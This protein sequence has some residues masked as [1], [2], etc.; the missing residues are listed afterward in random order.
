MRQVL[1]ILRN[2]PKNL[3]NPGEGSFGDDRHWFA[4][5]ASEAQELA[6]AGTFRAALHGKVVVLVGSLLSALLAHLER[7]SGL[8]L[9]DIPTKREH[10]L[11]LCTA[12][13]LSPLSSRLQ[14]EAPRNRMK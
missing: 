4:Q 12:S 5:I 10:W 8:E 1:H 7:N 6:L 14:N 2:T 3:K 13:L 11:K 9:L